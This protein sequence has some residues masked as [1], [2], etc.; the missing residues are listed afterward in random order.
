MP[1]LPSVIYYS[2]HVQEL[3]SILQWKIWHTPVHQRD[4]DKET[5]SLKACFRYLDATSRSF[6]A[7]IKELNHELLVPICIF[8]LVL[9]GLDTIEDDMSIA[10]EKKES[11]LRN[12]SNVLEK[13]GWTF[14]ENGPEV[15]DR[16]LLVHFHYIVEEFKKLKAPY[17]ETIKD[18]ARRMG[19]GMADYA[20]NAEFNKK[21]V[22]TV[23]DYELYCHYVAGLVGEGCT[24]LFVDGDLANPALKQR[25]DLHEGMGQFLQQTNIIRDIREDRDDGRHFW[26]REVWSKYVDEFDELFK[27]ENRE[28]AL[29]CSSE[30]VLMALQKAPDCLFYL[31]GLRDQSVF[32]FAA[33]PQSMAIAT[34][35]LC[36]RNPALFE[37]NIK[38]NK[39]QA[40]R[41]MIES[42]QNLRI[43]YNVFRD[44]ARKIH[45]K[46][47]PRDPNFLKISV[48]CGKVDPRR[49]SNALQ[50]EG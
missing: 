16:D 6:A 14:D 10:L 4:E 47:D 35:E 31:A 23:P 38:I 32:N 37:K 11:L 27:I 19:N 24:R 50:A 39:G 26:P 45:K 41:L 17:R 2:I 1:S 30:M 40:C 12:F 29:R 34:L 49:Q 5:P 42:S 25:K 18:I 21:G 28:K 46:N 44:Y 36:F 9:R 3:R 22:N 20:G 43:V 7:V 8:Y 48:A 13:D 33:I 15:K